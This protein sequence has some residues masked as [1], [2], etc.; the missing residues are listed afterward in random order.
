MRET[1]QDE[2]SGS[3]D[4]MNRCRIVAVVVRVHAIFVL[5]WHAFA[6]TTVYRTRPL[7]IVYMTEKNQVH[8]VIKVVSKSMMI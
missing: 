4:Y 7:V 6:F 1:V 8:L 2:S 3:Y 5:F